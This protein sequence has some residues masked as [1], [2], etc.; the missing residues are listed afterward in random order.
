MKKLAFALALSLPLFAH[1]FGPEICEPDARAFVQGNINAY[2]SLA[3]QYPNEPIWQ[4]YLPCE[5][6]P[7]NLVSAKEASMGPNYPSFQ[8]QYTIQC[9]QSLKTYGAGFDLKGRCVV[10][11]D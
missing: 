8:Y 1:A 10:Q 4:K 6:Q 5:G 2:I 3:K 9:G 7:L 11:G